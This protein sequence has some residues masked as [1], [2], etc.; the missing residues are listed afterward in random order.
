MLCVLGA[1]PGSLAAATYSNN[2]PITLGSA[3][4]GPSPYP[5]A[6]TVSGLAGEITSVTV[7]LVNITHPNPDDIDVLLLGPGGQTVLLM[8]DAGGAGNVTNVTVAFGESARL[9]IP[10]A[11][12]LGAGLYLPS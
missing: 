4:A 12:P 9:L 3:V 8:S 6:I 5:S 7:T 1:V 2:T 11:G 10:D